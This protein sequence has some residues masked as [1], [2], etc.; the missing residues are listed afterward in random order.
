MPDGWRKLL[1]SERDIS[2]AY[3][4]AQKAI[5]DPSTEQ[6]TRLGRAHDALVAHVQQRRAAEQT[7]V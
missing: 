2:V 4:A 3:T 7:G 6:K 1:E 5:S